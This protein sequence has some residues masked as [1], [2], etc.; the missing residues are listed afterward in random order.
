M[1]TP[2]GWLVGMLANH[3]YGLN[4]PEKPRNRGEFPNAPRQPVGDARR[5]AGTARNLLR[6]LGIHRRFQNTG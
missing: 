2:R 6:T 1:R 5:T 4:P 3:H